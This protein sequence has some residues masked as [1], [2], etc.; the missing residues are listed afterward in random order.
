MILQEIC[1]YFSSFCAEIETSWKKPEKILR[2]DYAKFPQ[3]SFNKYDSNTVILLGKEKNSLNKVEGQKEEKEKTEEA[4]LSSS[5]R[6]GI[7][8]LESLVIL[9]MIASLPVQVR[10]QNDVPKDFPP[11]VSWKWST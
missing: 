7:D 5:D 1:F 11:L 3:E 6:P 2:I 10:V 9:Y 4:S 8:H